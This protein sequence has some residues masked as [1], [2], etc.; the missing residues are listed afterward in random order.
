MKK[1]QLTRRWPTAVEKEMAK[2][3]QVIFNNDDVPLTRGE[4]CQALATAEILCSTVTD[5]LDAEMFNSTNIRTKLIANFGVGYDNIAVKAAKDAGIAITNTP[6]VLTEATAE[7]AL[8]LILMSARR[9]S[10]GERQVRNNLWMGW[11]PT[12]MLSTQ[13][14]GKTLGIVG[15]GR[16]GQ[17]LARKA[18]RGLD[19]KILY[20][21]RHRADERIHADL[22]AEKVPFPE[23]LN[24]SDFVSLHC[25]STPLTRHLI[26]ADA[27]KSMQAHS[28]LIN[29][30][31]GDVVDEYALM[32]ALKSG[33]IA[34]AGLDV[35][36]QEPT[37]TGGLM[38]LEQVVL[39]P[40]LGSGTTE[41]REAMGF[42]ALKNV[43]AFLNGHPLINPVM[44]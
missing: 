19:M 42:C 32:N 21:G 39:L 29:T 10:E 33:E 17:A 44:V 12:Y 1:I 6:G 27:L 30:S 18:H 41:T 15:M 22:D 34:G 23:L 7:I 3:G 26:D 8:T 20:H 25:P 2:V 4:L 14:T 11:G 31:R 24:R 36:E 37:V 38:D 16:I 43:R 9:A 35:Y 40:H 13:V 28:H 5:R